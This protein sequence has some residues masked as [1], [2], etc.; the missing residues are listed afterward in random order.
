MGDSLGR[1]GTG[2]S[3]ARRWKRT[4]RVAVAA[5]VAVL[6][7]CG[8]SS[9]SGHAAS[10][11]APS[12]P[13]AHSAA[14]ATVG[15][16]H[17]SASVSGNAPGAGA[18]NL[19]VTPAV[20]AE[21]V[22]AIAALHHLKPS[23]YSGLVS[24]RTY[25]GIDHTTGSY[26]AGADPMPSS[27]SYQAQVTSQD[28]GSYVVLT[29]APG[30]SWH[31]YETGMTNGDPGGP[32]P[33]T[34]PADVLRVWSWA[35][36]S[37]EPPPAP[38]ATEQPAGRPVAHFADWTGREPSIIYFSG[39]SGNIVSGLT[40]SWTATRAVGHGTW[41]YE[42][43]DPDCAQGTTAPYPAV[44]TLSGPVGGQFTKGVEQTSGPHAFTEHFTL[45]STAIGAA[46]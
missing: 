38:P 31:G 36:G 28:D 7:G 20:T 26:W 29:R 9:P 22:S 34:V 32:C 41:G 33:V 18:S 43:C 6:T 25:Y 11:P 19:T 15:S 17:V 30:G 21:L 37:C 10:T 24:G 13:P 40:W 3:A 2:R 39:D 45:P 35:A 8:G 27:S 1:G 4:A 14:P 46:S 16:P 5:L 44:V 23:D 12:Q 42:S